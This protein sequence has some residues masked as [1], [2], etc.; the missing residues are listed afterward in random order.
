MDPNHQ[1]AN[2]EGLEKLRRSDIGTAY[3]MGKPRG[4]NPK[5]N[6]A[7]TFVRTLDKDKVYRAKSITKETKGIKFYMNDDV[8]K[9]G[10]SL[11]AKMR[12]VVTTAK[13]QGIEAKLS[14]NKVVIG[15]RSHHSNELSLLPD[16]ITDNLKQEKD[17][18]DGIV[19]RGEKSVFSN[20][21][22]APLALRE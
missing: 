16:E 11:K 17:I 3:R 21:F 22:P 6:I 8:S 18:D 14:G 19:Y 5:R 7:V 12:R 9:D 10:R 1:G 13:K 2:N 15:T 4:K 20:F